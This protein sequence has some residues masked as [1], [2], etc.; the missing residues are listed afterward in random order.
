MRLFVH[1]FCCGSAGVFLLVATMLH[2]PWMTQTCIA[3]G[4]LAIA[5]K[6][7]P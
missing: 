5:T 2:E 6:G 4:I 1:H 7:R 3:A